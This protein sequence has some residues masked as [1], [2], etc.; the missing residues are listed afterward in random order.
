MRAPVI[1]EDETRMR[2]DRALGAPHDGDI[3]DAEFDALVLGQPGF[4]LSGQ[5]P[6]ARAMLSW[7]R[8]RMGVL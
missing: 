7:R 4:S 5:V 1:T 8:K 3:G 2:H 6:H